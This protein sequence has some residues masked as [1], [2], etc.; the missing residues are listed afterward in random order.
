[1]T[2]PMM[3]VGAKGIISV[4]SNIAPRKMSDMTGAAMRGDYATAATIHYELF[5]LMRALMKVE[6]NPSPIKAAMNLAGMDV[7]TVRLPLVEPDAVGKELLKN[8]LRDVG[9]L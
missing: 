5:P 9:L 1:M 2:V 6:T 4:L 8:L 3:S 7:G